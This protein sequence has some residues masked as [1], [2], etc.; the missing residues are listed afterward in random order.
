MQTTTAAKALAA[1]AANIRHAAMPL[2]EAHP[3]TNAIVTLC[4]AEEEFST[5]A[6]EPNV[7]GL[8]FAMDATV[9][10][11]LACAAV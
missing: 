5:V 6:D 4:D 2:D 3:V 11:A 9:S 10:A 7:K 1:I 8:F